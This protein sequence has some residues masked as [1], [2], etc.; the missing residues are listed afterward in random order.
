MDVKQEVSIFTEKQEA[1]DALTLTKFN[2]QWYCPMAKGSCEWQC[3]AHHG[4][5][6]EETKAMIKRY[7][8]EIPVWIVHGSYCGSPPLREEMRNDFR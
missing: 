7:E 5:R 2:K 1:E 8:T 3:P 4:A 6:I